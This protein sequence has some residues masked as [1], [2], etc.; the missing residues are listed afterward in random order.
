MSSSAA[1][2]FVSGQPSCPGCGSKRLLATLSERLRGEWSRYECI[3]WSWHSERQ[4]YWHFCALTATTRFILTPLEP[5]GPID[6]A[7]L[8]N[9]LAGRGASQRFQVLSRSSLASSHGTLHRSLWT[10]ALNTTGGVVGV[11]VAWGR[12]HITTYMTSTYQ[13]HNNLHYNLHNNYITTHY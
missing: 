6:I 2:L 4:A 3:S 12:R 11:G 5:T 1:F 8:R 10:R 9:C 7:V 13:L